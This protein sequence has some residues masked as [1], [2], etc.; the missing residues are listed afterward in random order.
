MKTLR[1]YFIGTDLDDLEVFEEQLE[2]AGVGTPQIHVLTNDETGAANHKHLNEV[3]SLAKKDVVHAAE[4]GALIG[5]AGALLV[6]FVAAFADLP[7][8]TVG[9]V[10]FVFLAIVI[11]GFCTWEGGLFGIQE[12]NVRFKRFD[13]ALQEGKHIFF[14][15][16]RADQEPILRIL[17]AR[18]PNLESAGTEEGTPAWIHEFRRWLFFFIDRNLFSQSQMHH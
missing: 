2:D 10:P 9:W 16:L 6:L 4:V 17:I 5:L 7:E 18:H 14:V 15:D 8:A 12:S 11:L 3:T 1:H 13:D